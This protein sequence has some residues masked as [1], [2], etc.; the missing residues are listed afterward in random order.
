MPLAAALPYI[1]GGAATVAGSAYSAHE[2]KKGVEAQVEAGDRASALEAQSADKQLALQREIWE[3]QQADY[4]SYL[5]QGTWGINR[6]GD[7][8][9]NQ[10]ATPQKPAQTGGVLSNLDSVNWNK[11]NGFTSA[12]AKTLASLSDVNWGSGFGSAAPLGFGLNGANILGDG[13]ANTSQPVNPLI[14]NYD[15][16]NTVTDF[17]MP[18]AQQAQAQAQTKPTTQAQA[19][20][21][22][23]QNNA[24][25]GFLNN[26]FDS[27]LASKG[28][29]NKFDSSNTRLDSLMKQGSG[30][31]NNPFDTYLK[32]KGVSNKFD[33][34]NTRLDSLMKSGSGQLNNPFDS[35]LAS[36][37]LAGGKFDTSNPAY[38]FQLKQG[39]QALD[40]SSAARGMGYSGAQMKASQE[41]GQGLA[42]QQ[43]DKEYN[44]ASGEFGDY[45]RMAGNEY[46]RANQQHTNEY[47]RASGE[48]SDYYRMAGNEY[49]RANQQYTN[50][51]NRASGE[52]GD[53]FNR[54]AG[55]SQGGQQAAGS[56][57][58]AGSQYANS[59]SNTFGNL[60]NAQTS[61]LG[62]QANARASGYAANA[63]AISGGLNSLTNL[64]GMSKFGGGNKNSLSSWLNSDM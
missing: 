53:Y 21:T 62:Q 35:Y 50:E 52:F 15:V 63:N 17:S 30:Q 56:M 64:Y 61:I 45:Y 10:S 19:Q 3:K 51:Y 20:A 43:Y 33:S 29:S 54:L 6:L 40:R 24:N 9:R 32:S 22:Q 58:N 46:D 34:S 26:P 5:E 28:V 2:A 38:Q 47:N 4:K 18:I 59:A 57:A 37:G 55:L 12:P 23:Y 31:L 25:G 27:Y 16:M 49:D 42:S 60:S 1:I 41:Y 11:G 36:K 44:R 7:L 14:P 48:F 39:Q 13:T 8:M